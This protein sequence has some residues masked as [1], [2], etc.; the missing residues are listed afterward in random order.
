MRWNAPSR[1]QVACNGRGFPCWHTV[2]PG[3]PWEVLL[4]ILRPRCSL[5]PLAVQPR[6]RSRGRSRL[7]HSSTRRMFVLK[8]KDLSEFLVVAFEQLKCS[9]SLQIMFVSASAGGLTM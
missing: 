1:S 6:G 4:G 2:N 9:Q 5:S 3:E 8:P 7:G